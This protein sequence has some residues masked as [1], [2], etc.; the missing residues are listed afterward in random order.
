MLSRP[1]R[2]F[3]GTVFLLRGASIANT[4]PY[5][6]A[7]A[8]FSEAVTTYHELVGLP[9]A[10]TVSLVPFSLMGLALSIFLGFRNSSCYDRWWEARKHWGAL[11][12]Q[13]RIQARDMALYLDISDE[14]RNELVL[15]AVGFAYAL[16]FHLRSEVQIHVL[17]P[18]FPEGEVTAM[19]G[20]H[21]V[22][23]A[24]LWRF[25]ERLTELHQ[26]GKVTEYRY[27][28]LMR[29]LARFS[30]IQGA[31]ER[32]KNT[33]VPISYTV[34]T[35]RIVALYCLT[36]PFGL[37]SQFHWFTP[38]AVVLVSYAFLG[39]DAVGT[40]I[41]D[42]FETDPND[43]PLQALANTIERDAKA[44]IGLPVPAPLQPE[45]GILM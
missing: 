39:L 30:D 29:G 23:N 34:L 22:P 20:E 9:E 43:L 32:I 14:E 36:L 19:E 28:Q 6:L 38:I 21:N 26:A 35:H 12:N 37:A 2:S 8:I 44:R 13:C 31:C 41:E 33:P 25:G 45:N 42:P 5:L 40:Q 3:P 4:W 1:T 7:L 17:D 18:F 11:I 16:K 10:A 24:V 27:V 15:R